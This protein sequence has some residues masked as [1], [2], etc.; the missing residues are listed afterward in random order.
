VPSDWTSANGIIAPLLGAG[1]TVFV[2]T[3]LGLALGV[4]TD[5]LKHWQGPFRGRRGRREQKE[6]RQ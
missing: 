4:L 5:A 2:I 3:P 6:V 1:V